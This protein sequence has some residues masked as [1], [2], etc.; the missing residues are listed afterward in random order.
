MSSFF[1]DQKTGGGGEKGVEDNGNRTTRGK[2]PKRPGFRC[3]GRHF[4]LLCRLRSVWPDAWP[5][6]RPGHRPG[7]QC[8]FCF[9]ISFCPTISDR[10]K[11]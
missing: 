8:G 2:I 9:G 7:L 10:T 3:S 4:V 5:N 6:S 1:V 11:V